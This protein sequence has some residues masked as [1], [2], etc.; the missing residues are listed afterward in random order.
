MQVE[1]YLK[2]TQLSIIYVCPKH[3][4]EFRQRLVSCRMELYKEGQRG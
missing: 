2:R 1:N 3:L 4:T